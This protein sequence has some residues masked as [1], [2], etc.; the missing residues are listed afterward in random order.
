MSTEDAAVAEEIET[1]AEAE[2]EEIQGEEEVQEPSE[3]STEK[4]NG[5]QARID[6]LT[7]LRRETERDRDYWRELA[8]NSAKQE[9]QET[10]APETT[11]ALKTLEDFDYD[12]AKYQA[13]FLQETTKRAVE[14][15]RKEL[16]EE[17]RQ[18]TNSHRQKQYLQR[19]AEFAKDKEDYY[20]IARNPTLPLNET[21]VE[22]IQDSEDGPALAYYLGK[23]LQ[24]AEQ[25]SMLTPYQAAK[26]MGR[27]EAKLAFDR[28]RSK[29]E[30]V[31]KAPAPPPKLDGLNPAIDKDPD[32]MSTKEWLA[33]RN[34]QLK[35]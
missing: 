31:T 19:E 21:M 25:I 35:R 34:K 17:Q 32:K 29:G 30:S 10:K 33:W 9:P 11:E 4:K 1:K 22:V 6:E 13:Y 16:E 7:R 2:V 27:I 14:A 26:E 23:N 5:V 8:L 18:T 15:A 28:E 24:I 3:S 20:N 12:E